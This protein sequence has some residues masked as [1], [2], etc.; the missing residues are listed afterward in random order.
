M[1]LESRSIKDRRGIRCCR[2]GGRDAAG[3]LNEVVGQGVEKAMKTMLMIAGLWLG[4]SLCSLE[5]QVVK[6]PFFEYYQIMIHSGDT[7]GDEEPHY[8]PQTEIYY[9]RADFTGDGRKSIFIANDESR[10]GP[11]GSYGWEV[12]YPLV[13]GGYRKLGLGLQESLYGPSYIGYVAEIKGYGIVDSGRDVV[14]VQYLRHGEIDIKFLGKNEEAEEED[15]PK[16]FGSPAKLNIKKMTLSQL[17][18][19]YGKSNSA[20]IASPGAK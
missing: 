11:H 12:Y 15:Y 6:D 5:A 1:R 10:Q 13:S 20:S 9:F 17:E 7:L 4:L 2:S 16:Y 14:S 19:K 18:E 8:S 3:S